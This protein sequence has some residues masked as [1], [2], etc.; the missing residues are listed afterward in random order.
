MQVWDHWCNME[1]DEEMR[2]SL[3]SSNKSV[4]WESSAEDFKHH[5]LSVLTIFCFQSEDFLVAF[6]KR[7]MEVA[8]N[9]EDVFLYNML[10]CDTCKDI[11]RPCKFPRT[12]RQRCSLKKRINEGNSFAKFHFLT[13]VTADH[14]PISEYP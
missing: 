3:Y 8:V 1:K 11:R 9:L 10:A 4:E 13:S 14:V 5:N 12:K 6:I 2:A 7:I